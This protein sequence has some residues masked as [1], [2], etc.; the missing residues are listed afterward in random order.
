MYIAINPDEKTFILSESQISKLKELL[1]E[2]QMPTFSF[3]ELDSIKSFKGKKEY[4]ER[5]L[6]RHIGQGSARAVF[7]IDD[8]KVLKLAVNQKGIAQNGQEYSQC[9]DIYAGDIFPKVFGIADDD[10]W[11]VAE[12][13]LPAKSADF[14]RCLGITFKEFVD[15]MRWCDKSRGNRYIYSSMPEERALKLIDSNE[16]L[17]EWYEYTQNYTNIPIGDMTSIRNFG[18]CMRNGHP[19]IVLLDSGLTDDIYNDYYKRESLAPVVAYRI[20]TEECER[21]AL[22]EVGVSSTVGGLGNVAANMPSTIWNVIKGAWRGDDKM[23]YKQFQNIPKQYKAG[24]DKMM[25][26]REKMS[27]AV[28]NYLR[29]RYYRRLGL[30]DRARKAENKYSEYVKS[31][32][33]KTRDFV[34]A[35]SRRNGGKPSDYDDARGVD[36]NDVYAYKYRL[37][38]NN[39]AERLRSR[40]ALGYDTDREGEDYYN[41]KWMDKYNNSKEAYQNQQKYL[42]QGAPKQYYGNS[43]TDNPKGEKPGRIPKA[44]NNLPKGGG[45]QRKNRI[46]QY[47]GNG[48]SPSPNGN[49]QGQENSGSGSGS[50]SPTGNGGGSGTGQTNP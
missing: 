11:I 35:I 12:Y 27:L 36:Y 30:Y 15:F 24:H 8:E 29:A 18:L 50:P 1:D 7:Q 47:T 32:N 31:G 10:S 26:G 25:S 19:Q 17:N 33:I 14:Q 3:E 37:N 16:D 44:P 28:K 13:V 38:S 22:N 34:D 6:G 45:N 48:G 9:N 39:P 2:A 4:C 40:H 42:S 23:I 41:T 20:I 46:G 49:T 5:Q 21:M 43:P